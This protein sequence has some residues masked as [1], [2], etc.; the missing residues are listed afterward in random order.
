MSFS[1]RL[2]GWRISFRS[3]LWRGL[4]AIPSTVTM[5]GVYFVLAPDAATAMKRDVHAESAHHSEFDLQ[6]CQNFN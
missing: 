3:A 6:K 1:S 2:R 5:E 4:G